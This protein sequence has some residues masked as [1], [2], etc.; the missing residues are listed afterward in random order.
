MGLVKVPIRRRLNLDDEMSRN[1]R[2][3][4]VFIVEQSMPAASLT[5]KLNLQKI[6]LNTESSRY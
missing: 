4:F 6:D 3:P 1:I 5:L 2:Y